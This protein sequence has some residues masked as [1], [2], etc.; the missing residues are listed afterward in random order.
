MDSF[1]K[2]YIAVVR[3]L[4]RRPRSE[5]EI[6]DYLLKKKATLEVS[7]A[8]ITK[9]QQQRFQNDLEFARW[10]VQSRTRYKAKSN[11]VIKMELHQKG[12]ND[13]IIQ[14]ALSEKTDDY[15][16]DFEK[17][18]IIAK[19]YAKRIVSLSKNDQYRRMSSYLS[20][21]GFDYDTIRRVIDDIL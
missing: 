15:K 5:K 8:I 14:S 19:K 6:S 7:K 21:K 1:E 9:I 3:L 16:T 17:A 20:Q 12:I 18:E 13:E 2:Y 10:W 4:T 11:L